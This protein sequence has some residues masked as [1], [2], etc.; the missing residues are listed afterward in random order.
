MTVNDAMEKAETFE[1]CYEEAMRFTEE[2][3]AGSRFSGELRNKIHMDC[4]RFL[5]LSSGLLVTLEDYGRAGSD[6][7]L[8]RN[9]HGAGFWDGDWP[10]RGDDLTEIAEK[11]SEVWL[12]IDDT[13][14]LVYC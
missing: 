14:G 4:S 2:E 10:G 7:W 1:R 8:T 9:G 3:V 5:A 6:F 12:Y 11:F 13:N